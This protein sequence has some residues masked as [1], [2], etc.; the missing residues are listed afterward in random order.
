MSHRQ[1]CPVPSMVMYKLCLQTPG[2]GK[3]LA[4]SF[5][6]H[7]AAVHICGRREAVLYQTAAELQAQAAHGGSAEQIDAMV[8]RIWQAGALTGLG[9]V[10][11]SFSTRRCFRGI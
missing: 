11:P 4:R 1:A 2:L 6:V 8:E 5:V 7:G 3:E 10:N 9:P